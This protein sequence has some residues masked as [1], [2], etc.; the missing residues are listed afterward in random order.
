LCLH[1][2]YFLTPTFGGFCSLRDSHC[3]FVE[4]RAVEWF[5]RQVRTCLCPANLKDCVRASVA[6]LVSGPTSANLCD[7]I[8]VPAITVRRTWRALLWTACCSNMRPRR[9]PARTLRL[10]VSAHERRTASRLNTTFTTLLIWVLYI[11]R[12]P[13]V[14][15]ESATLFLSKFQH[16]LG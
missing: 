5:F 14:S 1:Q 10:C 16:R 4:M 6:I 12:T 13:V 9:R 8:R 2:E 7:W 15:Q 11:T 3:C